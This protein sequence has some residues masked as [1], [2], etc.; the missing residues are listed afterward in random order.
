MPSITVMKAVRVFLPSIQLSGLGQL[1]H[2]AH[3]AV[4][5]GEALDDE[6][7][8]NILT[9]EMRGLPDGSAFILDNFPLTM[10]QMIVSESY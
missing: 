9:T 6:T 10:N 4:V 5:N 1:G 3:S 8:V 7:I 2:K